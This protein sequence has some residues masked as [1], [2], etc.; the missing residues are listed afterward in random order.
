MY[1]WWNCFF[2]QNVLKDC[3]SFTGLV[4]LQPLFPYRQRAWWGNLEGYVEAFLLLSHHKEIMSSKQHP[5]C[6]GNVL[7]LP[8]IKHRSVYRVIVL[9]L[10]LGTRAAAGLA[11]TPF[12]W[13]FFS[14]FVKLRLSGL[15]G[16]CY[17]HQ[18]PVGWFC[19]WSAY[20]KWNRYQSLL[21]PILMRLSFCS[22]LGRVKCLSVLVILFINMMVF[23]HGY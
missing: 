5:A 20:V 1:D 2:L 17:L 11:F 13:S 14:E 15:Q 9:Q 21:I 4:W 19:E 12:R 18:D 3:A 7:P 8:S 10:C 23:I 16:F 6:W 22:C